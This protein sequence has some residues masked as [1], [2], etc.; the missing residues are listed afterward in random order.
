[1]TSHTIEIMSPVGSYESLMAAIQ[2]GANSVYFGIGNLNMRA[3]SSQNFTLRDLAKISSVCQQRNVRSY[4]TLNAV[5]YDKELARMR[6]IIDA[7]K[8]NGI[9]AIIASDLAVME[10]ARQASMEVHMSTQTNIT[11]IE[12]VRFYAR[13]A[14]VIVTARE[15]SLV[16]VASIIRR[17]KKDRITGPSGR[18]LQV[19]IFAHGALCMA[20]SGKCYLSLDN[21]NASANRGSCYQLCRRPYRV[22][23]TDG[24][25]EMVVDNKFIM[26]PRDLKTI[27]FLD[28]IIKAGV[29]VLK[30]EG[31]GRS[32]E[33]VKT[34]TQCYREAIDAC[35]SGRYTPS[36][37]ER[38]NQRLATVYN[39]GFWDGY[40]LGR[41]VGEWHNQEG[42]IA[43]KRKTFLGKVVNYYVKIG[44]AEVKIENKSLHIG[45]EILIIGPTTGVVEDNITEI[46]IGNNQLTSE[47]R[48]GDTC[49]FPIGNPVRRSD[50][51]YLVNRHQQQQSVQSQYRVYF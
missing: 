22:F 51:V 17:I 24:E 6:A 39:R 27:G 16:Q 33:Y 29:T 5:I 46:R 49:S 32:P 14:D 26:S 48:K 36:N 34:V 8:R 47:A 19:E 9:T 45:D 23:D 7:A 12:A 44:V 35:F 28:K 1:M 2:S 42:S 30:I 10:Y 40:Y 15:L 38:W 21:Y 41:K 25:V 4:I 18:L 13:Y 50:K 43:T 37:I 11:N 31:R 20:I 3:R